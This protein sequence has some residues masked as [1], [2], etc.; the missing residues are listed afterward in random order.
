M[1]LTS[2]PTIHAIPSCQGISN[3]VLASFNFDLETL[4]LGGCLVSYL[5]DL[6]NIAWPGRIPSKKR[7]ST[8]KGYYFGSKYLY[9]PSL[10]GT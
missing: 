7:S 8:F 10:N 6:Q 4:E 2:N 1:L 3:E 5:K 9:F